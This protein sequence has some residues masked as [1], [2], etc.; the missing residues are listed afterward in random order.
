LKSEHHAGLANSVCVIGATLRGKS[1][2]VLWWSHRHAAFMLLAYIPLVIYKQ[3]SW[4]V[5]TA[6]CSFLVYVLRERNCLSNLWLGFGRANL[7]TLLRFILLSAAVVFYEFTSAFVLVVL[8][9]TSLVMD[10]F[11]GYV[12]RL[13]HE[14]SVFGHYLD[15]EVDAYGIAVL[16]ILLWKYETLWGFVLIAGLLRYLYILLIKL[17]VTK[18]KVEPKR[19]YASVI[20]V[21]VYIAM[22]VRLTF[23]QLIFTWLLYLFLTLLVVSFARSAWFQWQD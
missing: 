1:A 4:L 2:R 8:L 17:T 6:A 20:A 23:D 16:S 3:P 13:H 18:E 12:A 21:S 11:D 19:R 9:V 22:I 15:V 10:G 7:I 5:L 14:E